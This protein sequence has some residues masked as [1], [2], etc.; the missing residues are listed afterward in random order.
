MTFFF[1]LLIFLNV[2]LEYNCM[3]LCH[4]LQLENDLYYFAF[5]ELGDIKLKILTQLKTQTH[6]K[7]TCNTTFTKNMLHFTSKKE[8]IL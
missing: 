5:L 1:M 6:T 4:F 8:W 3:R 7:Q 2:G